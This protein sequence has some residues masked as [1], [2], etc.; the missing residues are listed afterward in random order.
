MFFL[1]KF[2]W[3]LCESYRF[4]TFRRVFEDFSPWHLQIRYKTSN[5]KTFS[6]TSSIISSFLRSLEDFLPLW[7]LF[8]WLK[9]FH[10]EAGIYCPSVNSLGTIYLLFMQIFKLFRASLSS[11]DLSE[12]YF[13]NSLELSSMLAN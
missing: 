8:S 4:E 7:T 5:I 2:E 1:V 6:I 9:L 13:R 3:F 12:G 10:I 11:F